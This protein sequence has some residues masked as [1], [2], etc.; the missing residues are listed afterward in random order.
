[1]SYRSLCRQSHLPRGRNATSVQPLARSDRRGFTLVEILMVVVIIGLLSSMF[2]VAYQSASRESFSSKTRGTIAKISQILSARMQEYES[3]PVTYAFPIPSGAVAIDPRE[4]SFKL[5]ERAR[6]L[7]LREIIRMELPDHPD[8]IKF[9]TAW[10]TFL[11]GMPNTKVLATGLSSGGVEV[12][13]QVSI[14]QRNLRLLKRLSIGGNGIDP[15]VGWELTNANA[16]LLYLIVADSTFNGSQA[17][18]L[19]QKSEVADTDGDG[20][21]EFIDADRQP[22][23]WIRWPTGFGNVARY[24]PDL[25]NPDLYDSV[26]G[27]FRIDSDPMDRM[28]TDPGYAPFASGNVAYRPAALGVPLVAAAGPDGIFG[29]RF[30]LDPIPSAIPA[31]SHSSGDVLWP[32]TVQPSLYTPLQFTDPWYPRDSV[33]QRLGAIINFRASLDDLTNYDGSPSSL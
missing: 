14:P 11:G 7:S 13:T 8:D 3:Y 20:L 10:K 1:M 6:L 18:E 30:S 9:T 4:S 29:L 25:L 12:F 22:I 28:A 2:L 31:G 32:S 21:N 15:L 27:I 5:V 33:N 16:E 26:N 23:Q 24:H 17:I 19:F